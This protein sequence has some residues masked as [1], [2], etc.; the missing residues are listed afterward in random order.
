MKKSK[1]YYYIKFSENG[2]SVTGYKIV[3]DTSLSKLKKQWLSEVPGNATPISE[4]IEF[5]RPKRELTPEEQ[6]AIDFAMVFSRNAIGRPSKGFRKETE[7]VKPKRILDK[8]G[9]PTKKKRRACRLWTQSGK[10]H[11]PGTTNSRTH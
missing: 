5:E 11:K 9:G 2:N 10:Y 7:P 6:A 3:K 1:V 8:S 4:G